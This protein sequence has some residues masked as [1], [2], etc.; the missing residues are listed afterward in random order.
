MFR[1]KNRRIDI[2]S[3]YVNEHTLEQ[4]RDR[5]T[6]QIDFTLPKEI[7][8]AVMPQRS[9]NNKEVSMN[10][11]RGVI[12]LKNKLFMVVNVYENKKSKNIVMKALTVL[13]LKQLKYSKNFDRGNYLNRGFIAGTPEI[14][15]EEK[16]FD[17]Q[18]DW[19]EYLEETMDWAETDVDYI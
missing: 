11:L 9:K 3:L 16:F 2:K 10:V 4:F 14:I 18:V 8:I 5:K 6:K 19:S 12:P 13:T 7:Q 17:T 15:N 1:T